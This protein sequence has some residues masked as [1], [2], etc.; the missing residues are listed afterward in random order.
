MIATNG[1][2]DKGVLRT[3]ARIGSMSVHFAE[4]SEIA[5]LCWAYRSEHPTDEDIQADRLWLQQ[6]GFHADEDGDLEV[7]CEDNFFLAIHFIAKSTSLMA[8]LVYRDSNGD[9]E[10]SFRLPQ[11]D[12]TR[13]A[14]RRLCR[15]LGAKI[16]EP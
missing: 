14:I 10:R 8:F 12:G 16:E 9:E 13:Q 1:R 15:E 6:I 11:S 4:P 2:A 3:V 5:A 7:E